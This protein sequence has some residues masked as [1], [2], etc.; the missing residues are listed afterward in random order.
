MKLYLVRHGEA[1]SDQVDPLRPLTDKG[2]SDT[3]KIAELL[4]NSS[5]QVDVIFH[6]IKKRAEQTAEILKNTLNPKCQITPKNYLAPNDSIDK[7]YQ[8]ISQYNNLMIVGHLPFLFKLL[9]KL[10]EATESPGILIFTESSVA[11]LK[12]DTHRNWQIVSF[13]TPDFS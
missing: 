11:V 1:V 2:K 3:Q 12:Q 8:E 4:K 7:I 5:I 10:I 6:S 13:I 9:S